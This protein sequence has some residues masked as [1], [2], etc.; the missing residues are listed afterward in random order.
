MVENWRLHDKIAHI[1]ADTIFAETRTNYTVG[2]VANLFGTIF[3]TSLD[4]A[5]FVGVQAS[6]SITLPGGGATGYDVPADQL[7]SVLR[8]TWTGLRNVLL[9]AGEHNWDEY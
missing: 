6:L 4:Y 1:F 2:N 5:S 7:E 8:E 9:Y 3:G